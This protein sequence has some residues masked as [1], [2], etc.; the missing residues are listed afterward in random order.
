MRYEEKLRYGE[1]SDR[2]VECA[3]HCNES[4]N[5]KKTESVNDTYD[6]ESVK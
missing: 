5:R 1:T 4:V 2:A 3:I 6:D